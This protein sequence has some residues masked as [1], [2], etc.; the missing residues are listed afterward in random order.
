MYCK[1]LYFLLPALFMAATATS[2]TKQIHSDLGPPVALDRIARS[3]SVQMPPATARKPKR[4][5]K[6][7]SGREQSSTKSKLSFAPLDTMRI[8]S[9]FGPRKH[10]ILRR[11]SFH[12]GVDLGAKLNDKVK[13]ISDG[14]VTYSGSQGALGN[15]VFVSHP[16][17]KVTS[18][19]A[20][21]NKVAVKSGEKI[22]SGKLIGY[23]GTTGRSTGV[24][25]HLTL[26]DQKTGKTLEPLGYLASMAR[27]NSIRALSG[28]TNSTM[29]AQD[30]SA[31]TFPETAKNGLIA[32]TTS[33]VKLQA[34]IKEASEKAD[35]LRNLYSEGIVARNRYLEAQIT[36][37]KLRTQLEAI[38]RGSDS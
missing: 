32:Q 24:H 21:L 19:Y 25:L 37:D 27:T 7:E 6:T 36:A 2:D 34:A 9:K 33:L 38:E 29:P 15:A 3:V 1:Q 26:K 11:K 12:S 13:V 22:S 30:K 18:I 20:H 10:P 16:K 8:T 28:Q 23:A 31:T 17:L 35:S 14:I 4:S 5:S